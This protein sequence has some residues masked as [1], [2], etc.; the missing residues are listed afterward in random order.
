ME[1]ECGLI[2]KLDWKDNCVTQ[3]KPIYFCAS[4]DFSIRKDGVKKS[5]KRK[6]GEK[7]QKE[8]LKI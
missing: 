6:T 7:I 3:I 5:A 1:S 4:N 2:C 8:F